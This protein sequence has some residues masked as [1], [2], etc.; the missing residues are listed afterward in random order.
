MQKYKK[1]DQDFYVT[2]NPVELG[3]SGNKVTSITWK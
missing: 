2:Q 3:H 1:R